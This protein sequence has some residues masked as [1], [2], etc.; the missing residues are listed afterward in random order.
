MSLFLREHTSLCF[1]LSKAVK[2]W[3]L[4]TLN[5]KVLSHHSV[6]TRSMCSLDKDVTWREIMLQDKADT[7]LGDPIQLKLNPS[8]DITS[9][10]K[11]PKKCT[12]SVYDSKNLKRKATTH[13]INISRFWRSNLMRRQSRWNLGETIQADCRSDGASKSSYAENDH[14]RGGAN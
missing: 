14:I 3:R 13:P 8:V 6:Q 5:V 11:L 7:Y 10:F 1:Q 4:Y 2:V 9:I 12:G